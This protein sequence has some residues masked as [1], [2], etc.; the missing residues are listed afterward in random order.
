MSQ[1]SYKII[2]EPHRT[3]LEPISAIVSH[4]LI[5]LH[6]LGSSP[7]DIGSLFT[8]VKLLPSKM[9]VV[10]PVAPTAPVTINNGMHSTSWFDILDNNIGPQS[11]NFDDVKTNMTTIHK[12]IE[13]AVKLHNSDYKKVFVGGFSQGCCMA[14]HVALEHEHK[15][16]G[17]VGY[18]GFLFPQTDVKQSGLDILL[19]HGE[20]DPLIQFEIA[21]ASYQRI[22]GL[23]GVEFH[24]IKGLGHS[25]DEEVFK[26]T[27][28]FF[29]RLE[30]N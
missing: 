30:L 6:G 8:S 24:N 25:L 1:H 13:E 29:E 23:E 16:G 14:L 2:K 17:V 10:M 3:I 21:K 20:F 28:N 12:E 26:H 4:T 27:I 15:L 22:L 18:S 11:I 9:R 7:E 19:T 5:F